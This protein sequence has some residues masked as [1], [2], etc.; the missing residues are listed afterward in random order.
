MLHSTW[1]LSSPTRNQTYT[2]ALDFQRHPLEGLKTGGVL[3]ESPT[4]CFGTQAAHQNQLGNN[5]STPALFR[6]YKNKKKKSESLG[7]WAL[8]IFQSSRM[9]EVWG[10]MGTIQPLR[11]TEEETAVRRGQ[12]S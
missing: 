6:T 12:T 9:H 3:P 8:V 1:D 10:S 5:G 4:Q 7:I 11:A 2:P